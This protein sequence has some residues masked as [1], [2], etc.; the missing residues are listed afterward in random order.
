MRSERATPSNLVADGSFEDATAASPF[1][2]FNAGSQFDTHWTIDSG[3]IDLINGYWNAKEGSKSIDM[4]GNGPGSISQL[5]NTTAGQTY[6]VD[7]YMAG[8]PDDAPSVK[9]LNVSI[10]PPN[11]GVNTYTFN[12]VPGVTTKT[13]M[14]WTE[15]SFTF[16]AQT[17]SETLTFASGNQSAYGPALDNVSVTAIPEP[18]YY[19]AS[20]L[21]GLGGIGLLRLRRRKTA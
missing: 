8:N 7:F 6:K 11:T 1:Q 2:T 15:E 4:S 21:L 5:L 14:G 10:A 3:S 9:T 13:N 19:Q 17:S 18:A 16:T 20:A 12:T